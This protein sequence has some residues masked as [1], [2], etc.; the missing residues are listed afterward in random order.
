MLTDVLLRGTGNERSFLI[1]MMIPHQLPRQHRRRLVTWMDNT[2][3]DPCPALVH[4]FWAFIQKKK[5]DFTVDAGKGLLNPS[6][7]KKEKASTAEGRW[8]TINK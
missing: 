3:L 8:R 5:I 7:D 6:R 4:V 1:I 2:A